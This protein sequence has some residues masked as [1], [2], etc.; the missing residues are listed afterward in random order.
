GLR[1]APDSVSGAAASAARAGSSSAAGTTVPGN[2]IGALTNHTGT[3]LASAISPPKLSLLRSILSAPSWFPA[4]ALPARGPLARAEGLDFR[5]IA[6]GARPAPVPV[7]GSR[8]ID[9][10]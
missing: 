9:V 4:G 3:D 2:T 10:Q 5:L 6:A 8:C 7:L 1:G